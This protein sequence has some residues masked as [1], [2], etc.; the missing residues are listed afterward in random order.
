LRDGGDVDLT[1]GFDLIE[2][3]A[4]HLAANEVGDVDILSSWGRHCGCV[5]GSSDD[6]K[7]VVVVDD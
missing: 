2:G 7:V 6:D 5:V 4:E 1:F 3:N